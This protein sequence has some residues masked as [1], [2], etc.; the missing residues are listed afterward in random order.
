[1]ASTA[2]VLMEL[3][4][5]LAVVVYCI[6]LVR[7]AAFLFEICAF[8]SN[9]A[10]RLTR[11]TIP[12]PTTAPCP[13][14]VLCKMHPSVIGTFISTH[15]ERIELRRSHHCFTRGMCVVFSAFANVGV[16]CLATV[17]SKTHS[18]VASGECLLQMANATILPSPCCQ[19]RPIRAFHLAETIRIHLVLYGMQ[20]RTYL[21]AIN[22]ILISIMLRPH[23][24]VEP[25]NTI[26]DQT[27]SPIHV[28]VSLLPE[29][30]RQT[31]YL[32]VLLS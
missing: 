28:P 27:T 16:H 22:R 20:N 1:M 13:G 5:A 31:I 25:S 26:R 4:C 24:L 2:Q 10:R 14:T 9:G 7:T 11:S 15:A 12:A 29:D 6:S 21:A 19:V 23:I 32:S 17:S 30:C 3:M 8:R 18:Y